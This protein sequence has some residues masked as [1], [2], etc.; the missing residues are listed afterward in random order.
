MTR[1]SE[2]TGTDLNQLG[3]RVGALLKDRG[4]T[5]AVAESSTGGLLSAALLAVPGASAYFRAGGVVYTR[6]A[7]ES[8][9]NASIKTVGGTKPLSEQTALYLAHNIRQQLGSDWGVGEIGAAGWHPLW[10]PRRAHLHC[11]GWPKGRALHYSSD[12]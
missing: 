12:R 2:T 5:I 10:R 8:L 1:S 11:G 9:L 7:W 4:Q 3:A 6:Q